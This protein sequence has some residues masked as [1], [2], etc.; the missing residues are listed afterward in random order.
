MLLQPRKFSGVIFGAKE[1]LFP[2]MHARLNSLI[3]ISSDFEPD[4]CVFMSY[5][6]YASFHFSL[7]Q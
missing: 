4:I 1:G 6:T 3:H 5:S 7:Y 2:A